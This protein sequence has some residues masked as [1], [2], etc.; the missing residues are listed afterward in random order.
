[1]KNLKALILLFIANM[2]SGAAQGISMIAI[3]WYFAKAGQM[4][5]FVYAYILTNLLSL[6]W[7]LY[8][9]TIVDRFKRKTVFLSVNLFSGL[10]LGMIAFYGYYNSGLSIAWVAAVFAFTFLNYNIH[11]PTLYAFVQELTDQKQ[12][13]KVTSLLEIQHQFTSIVAGVIAT[14]LLEGTKGGIVKIFSIEIPIP[15][16]IEPWTIYEI[17]AIDATTYFASFIII[18]G[19]TYVPT[20]QTIIQKGSVVD[21]LKTGFSFLNKN[22]PIFWFGIGS[23]IVFLTVILEG[24]Y[25][26]AK[27][28]RDHL[29]AGGDVYATNEISYSIGA[30][31]SGIIVRKVFARMNI[32]RGIII[33]TAITAIQYFIL[34][35][36][37]SIIILYCMAF[38][39]GLMNAGTRILRVTY[40]FSNVPNAL[41]G[42]VSSIFNICNI[43]LRV[44]FLAIFSISFFHV[45]N[46]IIYT[47][48]ILTLGL[49]F[50]MMLLISQYRTFDLTT[51]P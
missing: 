31:V 22:R 11:Y 3:P 15:F 30:L 49:I 28:I 29:M 10:I 51:K 25:I 47:F 20:I 14:F 27:Y 19:I 7:V 6:L 43:I 37:S 26:S 41:F 40:L 2:I 33:M 34:A 8:S 23:Y 9:G 1:M 44:F 36:T 24:F 46:N 48:D 13:S 4:Q 38:V 16:D 35:H 42:R 17:F 50:G 18:L 32:P 45:G 39:L 12:Y 21:R 5:Y